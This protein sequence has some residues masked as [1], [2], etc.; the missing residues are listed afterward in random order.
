MVCSK[1]G[2]QLPEGATFCTECGAPVEQT[3]V[4]QV[5]NAAVTAP[6][7]TPIL[8]LGILAVALSSVIGGLICAII[9][10]SKVKAYQAA[11]GQ[12]T[13]K[14]KVGNILATVGIICSIIAIVF[15]IIYIIVIAAAGAA[16]GGAIFSALQQ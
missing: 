8:I 13:G 1:C 4:Q 10:K 7:S 9:C 11:G 12:M 16:Y 3:P 15:W 5:Y 6:N 14:A 2:A